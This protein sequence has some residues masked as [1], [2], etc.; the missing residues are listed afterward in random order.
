MQPSYLVLG[1]D[2]FSADKIKLWLEVEVE[3]PFMQAFSEVMF[4]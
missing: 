4:E 2:N 1:S 3:I